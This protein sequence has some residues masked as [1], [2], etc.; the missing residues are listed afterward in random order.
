MSSEAQDSIPSW[1]LSADVSA[2]L[3]SPANLIGDNSDVA[4]LSNETMLIPG[5]SLYKPSNKAGAWHVF[6]LEL[7]LR[8]QWEKENVQ[9]LGTDLMPLEGS[10][11]EEKRANID[12]ELR[13][14]Y[15]MEHWKDK[16]QFAWLYGYELGAGTMRSHYTLDPVNPLEAYVG[17]TLERDSDYGFR[18]NSGVMLGLAYKVKDCFH[19]KLKTSV[20]LQ[21][22]Y[23]AIGFERSVRTVSG[24][25]SIFQ[26][27]FQNSNSRNAIHPYIAPG[28]SLV[29]NV[30]GPSANQKSTFGPNN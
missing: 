30:S 9:E 8:Y 19:L 16:E 1:R 4:F 6:S 17:Q 10:F 27:D 24:S 7:G 15:S 26:S 21:Y 22:Q 23:T 14:Q 28:L 20:G 25:S 12:M 3:T 5:I 18:M 2:F 11:K 29:F 13:M